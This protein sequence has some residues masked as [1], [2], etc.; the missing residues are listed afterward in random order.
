MRHAPKPDKRSEGLIRMSMIKPNLITRPVVAKSACLSEIGRE[1]SVM[2]GII[3]RDLKIDIHEFYSS[4]MCRAYRTT[5]I[6]FKVKPILLDFVNY[7]VPI[8][9]GAEYKKKWLDFF[10]KTS[11]PEG[12]NRII[13]GHGGGKLKQLGF[14]KEIDLD[15]SGILVYNHK[16][17]K[18]IHLGKSLEQ[19]SYFYYLL[20][21]LKIPFNTE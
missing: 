18:I 11:P 9:L 2:M 7:K 17:G 15:E 3:F 10:F 12:K 20:M 13:I 19:W 21:Q 6:A 4:N 1:G 14:G 5:E 8:G 16:S